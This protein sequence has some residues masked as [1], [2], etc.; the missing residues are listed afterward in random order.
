MAVKQN[1]TNFT[2]EYPAAAK[3]INELFYVGDGLTGADSIDEAIALQRHL[4][5]LFAHGGFTL[6]EWN[7]SNPTILEFIPDELKDEQSL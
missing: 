6:R 1:A 7:C 3:A 5:E 2:L 4:Q